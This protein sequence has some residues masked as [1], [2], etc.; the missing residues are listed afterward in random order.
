L[1]RTECRSFS[2]LP[3]GWN[4]LPPGPASKRFG[5]AWV[6]EASS[7]GL[8]VPSVIASDEK[9]LMLNPA[10]ER[11]KDVQIVSRE[12]IKLDKRLYV[13]QQKPRR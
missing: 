6:A 2:E 12:R 13:A 1:T 8:L 10:H 4:K 5:D 3:R 9:N 11:F 7:L